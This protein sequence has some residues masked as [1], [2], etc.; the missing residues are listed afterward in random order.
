MSRIY[1]ISQ[2]RADASDVHR[3]RAF[4]A[5]F[6][7]HGLL[8]ASVIGL[9]VIYHVLPIPSGSPAGA[10]TMTLETM[11]ITA[12]PPPS[13]QPPTPHLASELPPPLTPPQPHQPVALPKLPEEGVPVLDAQPS[14]SAPTSPAKSPAPS[15]PATTLRVA[16]SA[17]SHPQAGVPSSY[18]PGP[19]F[20]PHP[21]YPTEAQDRQETGTVYLDVQFDAVGGVVGA[22][23]TQSSGVPILDS[24]TRAFIRSYWHCPEFAG[25]IL[26][27]PVLYQLN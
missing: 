15:H 25:Q 9:G 1:L 17:Q 20:M 3:L 12:P 11:V 13:V 23:V 4:I 18:A 26:K 2:P 6:I 5:S 14:K 19:N 24:E 7:F 27:V 21:P 22:R 8:I 10:P 16:I